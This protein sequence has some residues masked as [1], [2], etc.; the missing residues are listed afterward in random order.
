MTK[1]KLSARDWRKKQQL[2]LNVFVFNRNH[3][4]RL[5]KFVSNK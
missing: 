1:R 2:K 4:L 5:S 3:K